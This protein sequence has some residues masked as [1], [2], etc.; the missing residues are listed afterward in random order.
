MPTPLLERDIEQ[1][2]EDVQWRSGGFPLMKKAKSAGSIK[3]QEHPLIEEMQKHY[4]MMSKHHGRKDK[5]FIP[6]AHRRPEV[7]KTN[8]KSEEY[9]KLQRRKWELKQVTE[10]IRSLTVAA[11][12]PLDEEKLKLEASQGLMDKAKFR[13]RM[14]GLSKDQQDLV[15]AEFPNVL[16]PTLYAY[17]LSNSTDL[18]KYACDL[19]GQYKE[20]GS[21]HGRKYYK[22]QPKGEYDIYMYYWDESEA[23]KE[24]R[25]GQDYTGWLFGDK[26]GGLQVWATCE[27]SSSQPPTFGWIMDG[28]IQSD[29]FV[30]G[31][32]EKRYQESEA[33]AQNTR[34]K[35]MQQMKEQMQ[36]E[37]D[38]EEKD[39]DFV[40]EAELLQSVVEPNEAKDEPEGEQQHTEGDGENDQVINQVTVN[41]GE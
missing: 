37:K 6:N 30:T 29:F 3:E 34:E 39:V 11:L 8:S 25:G 10:K 14:E 27:E 24:G 41:P 33:L 1:P 40:K 22:K 12:E 18:S 32:A 15:L 9:Q 2:G 7:V 21:N 16:L 38:R 31:L 28:D 13:M 36:Q 23:L 5:T 26:V 4:A 35:E 17:F 20:E 19:A